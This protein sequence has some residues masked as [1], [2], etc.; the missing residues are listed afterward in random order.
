[1][2]RYYNFIIFCSFFSFTVHASDQ[3]EE[4]VIPAIIHIA[5]EKITLEGFN[6]SSKNP[7]FYMANHTAFN[8]IVNHHVKLLK[9]RQHLGVDQSSSRG[10]NIHS[11]NLQQ[12][13]DNVGKDLS[14]I[15][16]DKYRSPR[17][18]E[19][20]FEKRFWHQIRDQILGD[21]QV[22]SD[23]ER[24]LAL[25]EVQRDIHNEVLTVRKFF[26]T[27]YKKSSRLPTVLFAAGAAGTSSLLT[28]WFS[29]LKNRE[30]KKGD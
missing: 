13:R 26:D 19:S 2:L 6:R 24:F 8:K 10:D 15:F 28:I 25:L 21:P 3:N 1:M 20:F 23:R 29:S 9:A 14:F 27:D 4:G 5:L 11:I 18:I 12:L 17:T 22:I 16:Y 7:I 30:A